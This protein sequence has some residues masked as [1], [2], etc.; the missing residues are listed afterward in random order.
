MTH[1]FKRG[2]LVTIFNCTYGGKF[3]IEGAAKIVRPVKD[4]DEQYVVQFLSEKSGL[5]N[6][7]EKYERFVDPAGQADPYAYVKQLNERRGSQ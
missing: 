6:L 5:P 4:V 7:G 1:Q 2:D 3:I